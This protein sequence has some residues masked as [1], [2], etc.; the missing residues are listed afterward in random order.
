MKLV[1]SNS[2]RTGKA[3]NIS[4]TSK[5]DWNK[6]FNFLNKASKSVFHR[7]L[8]EKY[9]EM[10][11]RALREATPKDTGDTANSWSYE[12]EETEG[13][14]RIIWKNTST[15]K[16]GIPIVVL[17]HYGHGTRNGGYVQGRDFINPAMRPVFDNIAEKAW[18][19]VVKL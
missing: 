7:S 11:V 6:T 13:S 5:G 4:I 8:F 9:G 12:I 17:L 3:M 2:I 18:E 10:G 14:V 15:T 1:R 16:D 19:E